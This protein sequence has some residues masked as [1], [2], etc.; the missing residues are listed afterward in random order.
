MSF[1][2]DQKVRR[3]TCRWVI[4]LKIIHAICDQQCMYFTNKSI[5]CH[6]HV[7]LDPF[8]SWPYS[9]VCFWFLKGFQSLNLSVCLQNCL[10]AG[11]PFASL[12][13]IMRH[14]RPNVLYQT[15]CPQSSTKSG[16]AT[17]LLPP[18]KS[19][20]HGANIYIPYTIVGIVVGDAGAVTNRQYQI[21]GTSWIQSSW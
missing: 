17:V 13:F 7:W 6:M 20:H 16:G 9:F 10:Y 14:S 5:A 21:K 15:K 1:L 18:I 19:A 11:F 4:Y 8:F 3:S 2:E 12:L